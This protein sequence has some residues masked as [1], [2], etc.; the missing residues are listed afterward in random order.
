MLVPSLLMGLDNTSLANGKIFD[1]LSE[2]GFFK[3]L[4]RQ[5]PSD[6]IYPYSLKSPLFSDYTEKNR[7]VYVPEGASLVFHPNKVFAFPVG[8]VL[9]KTFS[10]E[11]L[12]SDLNRQLLETRLLI[13]QANGWHAETYIWNSDNSDAYRSI[14]GATI[15]T[16]F[17]N[18]KGDIIDVRYRAPNLNQCKECHQLNKMLMPIGPKARNL[19]K[20]EK[21]ES[22]Y[23]NQ[24]V[25]WHE[26]GWIEQQLNFI[27]MVNYENANNGIDAR[28]R[29]YLDI[30]CAHCHIK[31]GSGDTTGLYL[32]LA[33]TDKLHLGIMKKPVATGRASF[34]LRYS[35]V[36]GESNNSILLKRMESLDPGIMMPESGRALAHTE[37]IEL[38]KRW[39]D[40][41]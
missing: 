27:E 34:N 18:D 20:L 26:I 2:Y 8:S 22:G 29:A 16:Q 10:Y 36:P 40:Q 39:I 31:G 35:I 32:D 7:F 37:G 17:S 33:E 19:D 6:G 4:G 14:V 15:D 23:K 41:L 11:N 21:Y 3:D 30:N 1:K 5:I 38:I 24:L 12:S 13:H 9:I 25:M 28:A